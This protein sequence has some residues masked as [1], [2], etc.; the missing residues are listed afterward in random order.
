MPHNLTNKF[1][2]LDLTVNQKAKKFITNIFNEWYAEKVSQQLR[3]GK[4]PADV[5]V[6]LKLSGLKPLHAKWIVEMYDFLKQEKSSI[7]KGFEKAGILEAVES[8]KAV[9]TRC[10]NPFDEKRM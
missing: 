8:A 2:P 7:I 1:Q 6:S 10:E 3:L 5:K 9:Y 4:A